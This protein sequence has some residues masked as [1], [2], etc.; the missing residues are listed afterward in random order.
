MCVY[1]CVCV[2]CVY[3]HIWAVVVCSDTPRARADELF[4]FLCLFVG[5]RAKKQ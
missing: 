4:A 3:I 1:V 2:G 5:S